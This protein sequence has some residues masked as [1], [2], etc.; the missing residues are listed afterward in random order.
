[1]VSTKGQRQLQ[2]S[3][4][5]GSKVRSKRTAD[6]KKKKKRTADKART[7]PGAWRKILYGYNVPNLS[8]TSATHS[9]GP[10]SDDFHE[11]IDRA[12]AQIESVAREMQPH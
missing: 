11:E 9:P 6:K 4:G 12:G 5:R 8:Q 7:S 10:A 1:M 2:G 3:E